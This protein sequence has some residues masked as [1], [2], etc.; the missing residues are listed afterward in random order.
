M[1]VRDASAHIAFKSFNKISR[2]CKPLFNGS[3]IEYY[4]FQRFFPDEKYTFLASDPGIGTLF[5]LDGHYQG[6]WLNSI[7]YD[8]I[9]TGYLQ[10]GLCHQFNNP[11]QQNTAKIIQD[12]TRLY[13]GIDIIIRQNDYCDSHSFA[14]SS[15]D[16]YLT[17]MN[18]LHRFIFYFKQ[19]A[20]CL[21]REAHA[22]QLLLPQ[23]SAA[24]N[25]KVPIIS[26]SAAD[27][28]HDLFPVSRYYLDGESHDVYL[29]QKE[30]DVLKQASRGYSAK[31]SAIIL[32]INHRTVEAHLLSIKQKL[33]V[34][35]LTEAVRQSI[36]SRLL[37]ID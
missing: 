36:L 2:L 35:K 12:E 4:C 11:L 33:G 8:A 13:H 9:Q 23:V 17:P 32:G 15:V 26:S 19:M 25:S 1:V 22:Q 18:F 30:L 14:A 31:E 6:S 10:W 16:I 29:T 3:V 20:R 5:F 21:L 37:I 7:N 24:L 34:T 27:S 28:A